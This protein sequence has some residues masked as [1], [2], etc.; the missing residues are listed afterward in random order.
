MLGQCCRQWTN[1]K[2]ALN[3]Y[4]RP[5]RQRL[6]WQTQLD[7]WRTANFSRLFATCHSQLGVDVKLE[8][9]PQFP[10]SRRGDDSMF[11]TRLLINEIWWPALYLH[12]NISYDNFVALINNVRSLPQEVKR[13]CVNVREICL[14]FYLTRSIFISDLVSDWLTIRNQGTSHGSLPFDY[15]FCWVKDNMLPMRWY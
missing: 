4:S 7:P 2:P 13:E 10:G 12:E 3:Q 15:H 9:P 6:S 11:Q 14:W 1:I 8:L 5:N